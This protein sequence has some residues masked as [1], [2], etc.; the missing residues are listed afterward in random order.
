MNKERVPLAEK[1][2]FILVTCLSDELSRI[3]LQ[4]AFH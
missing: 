3:T 4:L 2:L 1:R